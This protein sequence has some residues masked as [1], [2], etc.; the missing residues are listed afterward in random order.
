M[1][2]KKC[3]NTVFHTFTRNLLATPTTLYGFLAIYRIKIVL[4]AKKR[5][6]NTLQHHLFVQNDEYHFNKNNLFNQISLEYFLVDLYDELTMPFELRKAYQQNDLAV[7]E[8]YRFDRK[9]T[10][11][12]CV[13]EIMK[14]YKK[15]TA[16]K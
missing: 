4:Q 3:K 16:K 6:C 9:I 11:S 8:A 5:A 13:V 15:L 14:L 1:V 2:T 7:L 12:K 10:E